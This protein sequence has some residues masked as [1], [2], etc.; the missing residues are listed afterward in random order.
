MD[1][2]KAILSLNIKSRHY[3]YMAKCKLNKMSPDVQKYHKLKT[4]HWVMD[5]G[6]LYLLLTR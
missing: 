6:L 5:D 3:P 1:L 4:I 2:S